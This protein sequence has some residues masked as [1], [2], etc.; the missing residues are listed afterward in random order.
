MVPKLAY[1]SSGKYVAAFIVRARELRPEHIDQSWLQANLAIASPPNAR[2][3]LRWLRQAGFLADD[4]TLANRGRDLVF[5]DR[6]ITAYQAAAE[7]AISELLP[8]TILDAIDQG[9]I[10][11]TNVRRRF[12]VVFQVGESTVGKALSALRVLAAASGNRQREAVFAGGGR[13]PPATDLVRARVPETGQEPTPGSDSGQGLSPEHEKLLARF[14]LFAGGTGGIDSWLTTATPAEVFDRLL[15]ISHDH[16]SHAELNQLL[17]LSHE[18]PLSENFFRYYWLSIPAHTYCITSLAGF[19]KA[20]ESASGIISLDHLY[21][22]L[23]RFYIDAL[24]YFGSIRT[25]YQALRDRSSDELEK[26]FQDRRTDT[27][28]MKRRG[29]FLPLDDIPHDDR[30]LIAEMACKSYEPQAAADIGLR[31]TLKEALRAA[32]GGKRG[33]TRT[34]RDIIL[35]EDSYVSKQHPAEQPRLRFSADEILDAEIATEADVD[36]VIDSVLPRFSRTRQAA[37]RNTNHYL[38][39]VGE[40]DV[41]VATSMR[42]RKQFREVASLCD[43]VFGHAE[44]QPLSLR[45]FNPTLSSAQNHEDKGL[46]ECLMVKRS[47]VLVYIS[48]ESDSYGKDAEAAM[49]LSQGKPVIFYCDQVGRARF[50][51]DGHP[52]SRLVDFDSGVAV[53]AMVTSCFDTIVELLHRIFENKMQYRLEQKDGSGGYLLLKEETTDSTVRLQTSDNL[54]RE[55]FWNHYHTDRVVPLDIAL[56]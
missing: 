54:L 41:Y 28:A 16:L 39:M 40:L 49:A 46:I 33:A 42:L 3:L 9:E 18:A 30:Y 26:F 51:R 47:K 8:E 24:L 48:G 7:A 55:T 53:G 13:P 31:E 5:E 21:W 32:E 43:H 36:K 12:A 34:I 2:G 10:G 50:A 15:A 11:P 6:D 52:L 37:I 22:G 35:G 25:A 4:G 45:H 27:Q 20:Y 23:Y 38:S 1:P 14:K 56:K 29:P 44:L 19:S 17:V